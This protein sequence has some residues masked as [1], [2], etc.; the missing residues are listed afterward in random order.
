MP[1][2]VKG[3]PLS[4]LPR[5]PGRRS[6]VKRFRDKCIEY[7]LKR[8]QRRFGP[9]SQANVHN[10]HNCPL[11]N[12][13]AELRNAIWE[14][15][16]LPYYDTKKHVFT[17]IYDRS[18][19][20][21]PD[22][23][24]LAASRSIRTETQAIYDHAVA[25]FWAESSLRLTRLFPS[26]PWDKPRTHVI[27]HIDWLNENSLG[28]VTS[29]V[30]PSEQ[31]VSFPHP[32]HSPTLTFHNGTWCGRWQ[33]RPSLASVETRYV[34]LFE[35]KERGVMKSLVKDVQHERLQNNVVDGDGGPYDSPLEALMFPENT[36]K[37]VLR[38][39]QRVACS[40]KLTKRILKAMVYFQW[41]TCDRY[42]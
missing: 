29:L 6:I 28:K 42:W 15:A 32:Y 2:Q 26:S 31:V 21:Y 40:E 5:P 22:R 39:V 25:R 41:Y 17:H 19:D 35:K 33:R 20:V 18:L 36:D 38:A 34:V 24:V 7:Q 30:L 23:S 13:P 27:P 16:I 11:L 3:P 4:P 14:L 10:Q 1:Q 37:E 9:I 8:D 12:L